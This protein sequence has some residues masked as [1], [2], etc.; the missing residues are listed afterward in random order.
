MAG[1]GGAAEAVL[2]LTH[3][4]T[5]LC[6]TS[7]LCQYSSGAKVVRTASALIKR[8]SKQKTKMCIAL[9][10]LPRRSA[11]LAAQY[12]M[13]LPGFSHR[14]ESPCCGGPA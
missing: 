8:K 5:I 13:R 3:P 7:R 1:G 4:N 6:A 2:L 9:S 12:A 10:V 14:V 11:L